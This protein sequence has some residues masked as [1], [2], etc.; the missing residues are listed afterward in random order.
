MPPLAFRVPVHVKTPESDSPVQVRVVHVRVP[1]SV[2]PVHVMF[3]RLVVPWTVRFWVTW[4]VE[5]TVPKDPVPPVNVPAMDRL[6]TEV[7]P[8]PFTKNGELVPL[9]TWKP[10]PE[11]AMNPALAETEPEVRALVLHCSLKQLQQ[12]QSQRSQCWTQL[13]SLQM[14]LLS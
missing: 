10:P 11:V 12:K 6:L 7:L 14:H 2:S 9:N 1:V 3:C 13:W 5:I 4:L 8:L